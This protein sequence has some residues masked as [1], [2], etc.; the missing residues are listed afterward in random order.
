MKKSLLFLFSSFCFILAL[1]IFHSAHAAAPEP[2]M[3]GINPGNIAIQGVPTYDYGPDG[4]VRFHL[5]LN[6]GYWYYPFQDFIMMDENCVQ[7]IRT[8]TPVTWKAYKPPANDYNF[9]AYNDLTGEE[10]LFG[11]TSTGVPALTK[12]IQLG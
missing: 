12:K 11:W 9:A 2:C 7:Q 5:T 10:L 1:G 4:L 6:P 3:P 8:T